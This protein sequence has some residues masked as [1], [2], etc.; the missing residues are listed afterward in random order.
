MLTTVQDLGR[1][2]YQSLGVSVSG[3]MDTWSARLANRLIGNPDRF[4]VLEVTLLG[5]RFTAERDIQ[6]GVAGADFEVRIGTEIRRVPFASRVPRGTEVA[7]GARAHGA[8]AYL[9]VDGGIGALPVLGSASTHLLARLGGFSGR[10]LKPGDRVPLG[11]SR[12]LPTPVPL[13]LE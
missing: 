12:T 4:A 1:Y 2:G 13:R 11:S 3:A 10:P 7:F 6:I 8:R 5:P 9:A